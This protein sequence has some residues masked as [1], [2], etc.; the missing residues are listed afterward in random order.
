MIKEKEVKIGYH[1]LVQR[2][3]RQKAE[4]EIIDNPLLMV[5]DILSYVEKLPKKKKFF[6]LHNDKFCFLESFKKE[7]NLITV[8]IFKSARN[9]FRPNLINKRTGSERPN[10]KEITEGD[11]EKTHFLIKI[12]ETENDVYL[13][14]ENNFYGITINN[15]INYLTH[16]CKEFYKLKEKSKNF[17]IKYSIIPRSNFLTELEKLTRA[18]IAEVY[19]DKQLLGSKALNFSNRTI[20]LKKDLKLI[21]TASPRESITE[22]AVDLFNALNL[23]KS[24]ITKVRVIGKDENENDV[25]LDTSF[26]SKIDFLTIDVNSDTGEINSIQLFSKLKGLAKT[27]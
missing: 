17:S 26:M 8:G 5:N 20:S 13:L 12:D 25:I 1:T 4:D 11:I 7:T 3:W 14:L 18:K 2:M 22:V 24:P 10:P 27:I 16:F 15:F 6:D 23:R 21:A 19:F 9:E